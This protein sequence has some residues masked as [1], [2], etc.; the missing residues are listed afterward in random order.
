MKELIRYKA[1]PIAAGIHRVELDTR[2][3]Q[4]I[5]HME[6]EHCGTLNMQDPH[7]LIYLGAWSLGSSDIWQG[8]GGV[9]L[10]E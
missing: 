3:A 1:H 10:S 7:R 4:Q 6:Q 2:R 5:G 8:L 9:S